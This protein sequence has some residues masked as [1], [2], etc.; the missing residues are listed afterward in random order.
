MRN[1]LGQEKSGW[2]GKSVRKVGKGPATLMGNNHATI[3]TRKG[4]GENK[5]ED[6]TLRRGEVFKTRID[7]PKKKRATR[8]ISGEN[9]FLPSSMA[10]GGE[11]AKSAE[12]A[13]KE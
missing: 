1:W 3:A 9:T 11:R 6:A 8:K 12:E 5:S 7:N 4:K 13:I 10:K 2:S